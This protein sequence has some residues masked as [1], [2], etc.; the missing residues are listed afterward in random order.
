MDYVRFDELIRQLGRETT[1]RGALGALLG[2]GAA[3]MAVA[4]DAK[5]RH[6]KKKKK[7]K[8]KPPTGCGAGGACLVFLS[9]QTYNGN[10]GG[11]SGADAKCQALADAADLPGTYKAWLSDDTGSPSTRFVK[12]TGPYKLVDGTT[13]AASWDGLTGNEACNNGDGNCVDHAINLTETGEA[14]PGLV[15]SH[16][17]SNGAPSECTICDDCGNWTSTDGSSEVGDPGG[18]ETNNRWA[19]GFAG[20]A[21]TEANGLYCFQQS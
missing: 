1:R 7:N 11:L 2:T 9:S 5:R 12:S 19:L 20:W 13:F 10:L 16:T 21:C 4:A 3:G 17:D 14:G 18:G 8:T 6:K 15:W